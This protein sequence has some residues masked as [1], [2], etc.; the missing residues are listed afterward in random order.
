MIRSWQLR[1]IE[2]VGNAAVGY[3]VPCG[4]C[5]S[6]LFRE[7]GFEEAGMKDPLV[8]VLISGLNRHRRMSRRRKRSHK[9]SRKRAFKVSRFFIRMW[10]TAE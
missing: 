2:K 4:R 5:D 7:K 3:Y 8:Y 6:C 10:L 9:E 1:K